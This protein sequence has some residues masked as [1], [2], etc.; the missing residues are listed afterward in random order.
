MVAVAAEWTSEFICLWQRGREGVCAFPPLFVGVRVPESIIP[1]RKKWRAEPSTSSGTRTPGQVRQHI[2]GVPI[3][4]WAWRASNTV[5][6]RGWI[7]RGEGAS[8]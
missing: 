3:H 7:Y 5:A 2:A 8:E 6:G 1:E 4:H